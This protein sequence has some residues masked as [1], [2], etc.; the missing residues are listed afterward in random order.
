MAELMNTLGMST[1]RHAGQGDG[2]A[3]GGKEPEPEKPAHRAYDLSDEEDDKE[4]PIPK[5]AVILSNKAWV[6]VLPLV[7]RVQLL[8]DPQVNYANCSVN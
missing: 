3:G 2:F 8:K 5:E 6:C 4:T 7:G 1:W